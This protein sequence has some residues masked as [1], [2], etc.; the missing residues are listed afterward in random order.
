MLQSD[1]L[2]NQ[3]IRRMSLKCCHL[4]RQE[5]PDAFYA[6]YVECLPA[7]PPCPWLL[8]SDQLEAAVCAL[9][10]DSEH[11][12]AHFEPSPASTAASAT[13]ERDCLCIV[14]ALAH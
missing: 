14:L 11:V 4:C 10:E 9:G 6:P 1:L 2:W 13:L 5:G 7:Q 3:R 8:P 12:L